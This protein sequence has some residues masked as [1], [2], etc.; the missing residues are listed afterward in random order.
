MASRRDDGKTRAPLGAAGR[1]M[2]RKPAGRPERG[3]RRGWG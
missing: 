2:A 1:W 3:R